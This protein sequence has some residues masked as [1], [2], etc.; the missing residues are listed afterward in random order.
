MT[1]DRVIG[2][3]N[4]LPWKLP[5]DMRW[6]RKHTL[7]KPVIMGRKTYE[8]FGAKALPERSNIILTQSPTFKT[9]DAIVT[10]SVDAAIDAAGNATEVMIIGGASLYEQ[11]LP[12]A[13]K[14]YMTI[15][16]ANI[17]GDTWFPPINLKQW[18]KCECLNQAADDK[19]PYPC[20]FK[21]FTRLP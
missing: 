3:N 2:I 13:N 19:N 15:V 21:I 1:D 18:Q 4:Q 17:D 14:L 12:I 9:T 6:F 8:S 5:A 7:G 16:H 11:M 10:S 20:T